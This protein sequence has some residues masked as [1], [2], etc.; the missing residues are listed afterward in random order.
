MA[1]VS[2]SFRCK[3]TGVAHF[4]GEEYTGDRVEELAALGYVDA[5]KAK[6]KKKSEKE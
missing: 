4:I 5:G 2:K 1:T 6:V 3:V